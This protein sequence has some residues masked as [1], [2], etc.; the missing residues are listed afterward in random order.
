MQPSI[1]EILLH[2]VGTVPLS[3]APLGDQRSTEPALAFTD[4]ANMDYIFFSPTEWHCEE[5]ES[6][7]AF[8]A[9][10]FE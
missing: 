8:D 6:L 7:D 5:H 3:C 4:N 9:V 1:D 10:L 2:F